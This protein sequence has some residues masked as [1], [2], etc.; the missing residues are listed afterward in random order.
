MIAAI[1]AWAVTPL[2]F[3]MFRHAYI[4]VAA[5]LLAVALTALWIAHLMA[6]AARGSLASMLRQFGATADE[7]RGIVAGLAL[8]PRSSGL[9]GVRLQEGEAI[10][11]QQEPRPGG[12]GM[13]LT[14][15]VIS[16][17]QGAIATVRLTGAG[18]YERL[19][20]PGDA[21]LAR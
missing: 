6:L 20:S 10:S 11:V 16:N 18:G 14:R 1:L 12:A 5:L 4:G 8:P 15:V 13:R 21:T 7:A 3:V 17:A 2:A 19:D 9:G